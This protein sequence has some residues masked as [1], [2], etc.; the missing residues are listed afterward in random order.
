[1]FKQNYDSIIAVSDLQAP[2][3][4]KDSLRFI[5]AIMK[6]YYISAKKS[7]I[8][9]MGDEEDQHGLSQWDA[10]PDGYSAGHE[11]E[12]ARAFLKDYFDLTGPQPLCTSNHSIRAYKRMLNAG[13]PRAFHKAYADVLGAPKGCQWKDRWVFNGIIFEHGEHVSGPNAALLAAQKNLNSTVIGHQHSHGGVQYYQTETKRIFG[14][15]S[16]CLIDP[17]AYAFSYGRAY[18]SKPTLG[19]GIILDTTGYFIP[20]NTDARGNWDGKIKGP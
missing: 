8:I 15:N 20:M 11:H 14:L 1:M 2:F 18:R 3:Q 5:S 19:L 17:P 10:D 9:N 7:L 4:H 6:R 13:V 12:R 16:G